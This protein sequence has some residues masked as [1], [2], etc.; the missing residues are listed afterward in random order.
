MSISESLPLS[1]TSCKSASSS[2]KS[3][4]KVNM[5]PTLSKTLSFKYDY[6]YE[7]D[8]IPPE[9]KISSTYLP[10]LNPHSTFVKKSCNPWM[11]IRSLVQQKPKE[12]RNML[13]HQNLISNLFLQI[14]K[15]SSPLCRCQRIF[16]DSGKAWVL[17]ISIL[18]LLEL[19]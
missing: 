1:S 10:L 15:N 7:V 13:L 2:C 19:H 17:P 4:A 18:V 12:S 8:V 16:P 14:K 5:F 6:L 11:Q 3:L 9:N